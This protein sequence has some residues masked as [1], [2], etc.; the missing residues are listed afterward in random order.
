MSPKHKTLTRQALQGQRGVNVLEEVVLEMGSRW[1]PSGPNEVGIDGYIELFDP[2]T[3]RALG[4]TVAAQSK[5]VTT[6]ERDTPDTFEFTCDARDLDY[7]M[8]GNLPVILVVSR[9]ATR[10][11]FWISIKEYFSDPAKRAT[12]KAIFVKANQRFTK[13]ALSNLLQLGRSRD[14][15]LYLAPPPREEIL[16]A[17]LLELESSPK[18]IYSAQTRHRSPG[19]ILA[20]LRA[21]ASS[22]IAGEWISRERSIVAFFDLSD[23]PWP[24]VCDEGTVESFPTTEWSDSDDPD[25]RRQ[26]VQLLGRSLRE[27]LYP[28]GIRY[29][30]DEDCFAFS[31][32]TDRQHT[33]QALQRRSRV[34]VVKRFGRSTDDGRTYSR[35]RHLAFRAR[36]RRLV[37][38]WYLEITPTYRFTW[39]GTALDRFH[40]E[41]LS[42]IKRM[43]GNRAVLS[44]VMLWADLLARPEFTPPHRP[45]LGFRPPESF[46]A[47]VGIDDVGWSARD[48][49]PPLDDADNEELLLLPF[50]TGE[51]GE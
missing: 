46:K 17:N 49:E 38:K 1:S 2:Q 22:R 31:G 8:Q 24:T 28:M 11:A 14:L 47:S 29:W 16:H 26:F 40:A 23:P 42:G 3:G 32:T 18:W 12:G 15:G 13:D 35:I 39:N 43:E 36:F 4:T 21:T 19:E 50:L 41:W 10:E 9:P 34:T 6:F 37:D 27:Q 51:P 25:R 5:A 33:Y 7:W 48:P 30:P 45:T 44:H 20:A